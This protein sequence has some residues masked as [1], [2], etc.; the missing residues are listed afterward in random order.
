MT[1]ASQGLTATDVVQ[2]ICEVVAEREKVTTL[3]HEDI[4]P[5]VCDDAPTVPDVA[6]ELL[7]MKSAPRCS[8]RTMEKEIAAARGR[9]KS[10][11]LRSPYTNLKNRKKLG[12]LDKKTQQELGFDAFL[13]TKEQRYLGTKELAGPS[14]FKLLL[15]VKKDLYMQH[16][17]AYCCLAAKKYGSTKLDLQGKRGHPKKAIV[18]S[19]FFE[20]LR[21]EF[22]KFTVRAD[23]DSPHYT[24]QDDVGFPSGLIQY[25]RGIR[26]WWSEEFATVT[27]VRFVY[28]Q[29]T[30]NEDNT[31]WRH[32]SLDLLP[33]TNL[34]P[35][36]LCEA[37]FFIRRKVAPRSDFFTLIR[38]PVE[39]QY[40]QNDIHSCGP[41][42]M[43]IIEHLITGK[44][45][46]REEQHDIALM[47]RR[48]AVELW[49]NSEDKECYRRDFD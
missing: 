7:S 1:D 25:V 33:L 12:Q 14:F 28:Y 36:L 43:G 2:N 40:H 32:R 45:I 23:S 38:A 41:L 3:E 20:L 30:D 29:R 26:P 44:P 47:R 8:Q 13:K 15:G 21:A 24:S 39:S 4:V 31:L 17:D 11:Y 34:L 49:V 27:S 37:S 5:T 16:M 18:D 22:S 19:N 35:S 42:S 9:K 10:R 46:Q 48:L 6:L